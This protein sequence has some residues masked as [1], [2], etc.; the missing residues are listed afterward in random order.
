MLVQ[1]LFKTIDHLEGSVKYSPYEPVFQ[2]KLKEQRQN[3]EELEERI[4]WYKEELSNLN[5]Q[6]SIGSEENLNK[7]ITI[8]LFM[9]DLEWYIH[10]LSGLKDEVFELSHPNIEDFFF[11]DFGKSIKNQLMRTR[12]YHNTQPIYEVIRKTESPYLK[13]GYRVYLY[14]KGDTRYKE[15]LEVVDIEGK[16]RYVITQEGELDAEKTKMRQGYTIGN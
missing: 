14:E 16:V 2:E 1:C 13:T 11:S 12:H 5:V 4:R 10:E 9:T 7:L 3:I 8:H 6:T 15:Y